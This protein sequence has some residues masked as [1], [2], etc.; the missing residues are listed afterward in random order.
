MGGG[1]GLGEATTRGLEVEV[2]DRSSIVVETKDLGK[3]AEGI[4][5]INPDGTRELIN[6]YA[7]NYRVGFPA[8]NTLKRVSN[9]QPPQIRS[10]FYQMVSRDP[11]P[12]FVEDHSSIHTQKH[13][14]SYDIFDERLLEA[15]E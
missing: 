10:I 15:E 13:S 4:W 5:L 12:V 6:H 9:S 11:L 8:M 3:L 14:D 7:D 2:A 1:M